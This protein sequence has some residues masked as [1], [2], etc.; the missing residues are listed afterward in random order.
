MFGCALSPRRER[1]GTSRF[2]D[3]GL[4]D[5]AAALQ[6]LTGEAALAC[7]RRSHRYNRSVFMT[8]PLA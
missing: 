4:I 5:A 3:R 7:L 2:I 6:H 8:L 1:Q